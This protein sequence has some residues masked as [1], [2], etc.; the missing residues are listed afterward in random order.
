MRRLER[1]I[2]GISYYSGFFTGWLVL[3]IMGLTMVEV[4]S[5]YVLRHPIMLA[6]EFGGY[7]F[8]AIALLG[9][10]YTMK[11]GRHIRIQFVVNRLPVKFS[12]W[13][14]VITL[15]AALVYTL[16]A[17]YVSYSFIADAFQRHIRAAS[18][19]MTPLGW[20]QLVLP[21]GFTLLSIVLLA[22]VAKAI[23]NLRSGVSTEALAKAK[24]E[25]EG[26]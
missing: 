18:H 14:R 8:A 25:E 6:D 13:L 19:L 7:S 20:P 22:E 10:A 21:I 11:E 9:L 12:N 2:D 26:L 16:I 5:R 1:I 4:V 24:D 15:S 23:R 17:S 3:G